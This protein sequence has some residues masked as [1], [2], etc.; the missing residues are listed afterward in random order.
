[1][2]D[3]PLSRRIAMSRFF[4]R[5]EEDI[6]SILTFSLRDISTASCS[7]RRQSEAYA[8]HSARLEL[9]SAITYPGCA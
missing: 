6:H 1:M 7:S 2:T 4:P 5:G 8:W 3:V 9:I